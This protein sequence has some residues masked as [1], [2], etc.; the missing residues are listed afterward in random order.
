MSSE[1]TLTSPCLLPGDLIV[2]FPELIWKH[3]CSYFLS[4]SPVAHRSQQARDQICII[5]CKIHNSY[6]VIATIISADEK[7]TPH[8]TGRGPTQGW[9]RF[10]VEGRGLLCFYQLGES[11]LQKLYFSV[12]SSFFT[13]KTPRFWL[14]FLTCSGDLCAPS[15]IATAFSPFA[16]CCALTQALI[17]GKMVRNCSLECTWGL[18][19]WQQSS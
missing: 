17:S 19:H 12:R 1:K 15:T 13:T 16:G 11:S 6:H 8:S 9:S 14:P 2:S 18:S 5:H 7:L 4:I 3:L 10:F